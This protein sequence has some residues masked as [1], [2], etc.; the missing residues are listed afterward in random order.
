MK[1]L[2]LVALVII[3]ITSSLTG[4]TMFEEMY[5]RYEEFM[6]PYWDDMD[7]AMENAKKLLL[8]VVNDDF[9]TAQQYL[10]P[11]RVSTFD[12]ERT[13]EY[14]ENKYEVDFSN[15]VTI[16]KYKK[17]ETQIGFN[18]EYRFCYVITVGDKELELYFLAVRNDNGFGIV[19]ILDYP[20]GYS[21]HNQ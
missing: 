14:I 12:F 15:G 18:A 10:H 9:E 2:L 3:L 13:F 20:S 6:Q 17:T 8:A 5:D 21:Q 1:K 19:N 16:N 4:C 7:V 11:D